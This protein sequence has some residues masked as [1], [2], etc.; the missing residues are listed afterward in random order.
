MVTPRARRA[1][2][3]YAS[4]RG[5]SERR[6]CYLC[7]TPRSALRYRSRR[8]RRDRHLC[9]ALK[10]V[11]KRYPAWGYRLVWGFL[12]LRGW[13]VN[14]KRV[15]RLWRALG[16]SLPPFKPSRKI[17]SGVKLDQPAKKRNDVWAWDLVHDSYGNGQKFKCLTIKD[18]ATGFCLMIH[19][20]TRIQASDIEDLLKTLISRY[21]RP[22]AI[23]SDNGRELIAE[24]LQGYMQ[25]QG[26]RAAPIDP[27]KPW[28]NG[29]NESFNG[30]FRN[31]CLNA[32]IFGSLFEAQVVIE[33]W[34]NQYNAERPHSS[35][36]YI[37]PEMAYFGLRS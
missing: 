7:S 6:A 23:R 14:T 5:L 26:I 11:A 28:Q 21:G 15:Y 22:K 24:A 10:I 2:A 13:T 32:E 8:Q 34:R 1:M 37:T 30:T 20:D 3:L 29:S 33:Q 9:K 25:K 17:K 12:R 35:Q 19:T 36:Q 27:G 31:E 18:E 16:L 4:E